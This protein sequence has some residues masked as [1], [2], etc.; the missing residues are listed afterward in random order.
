MNHV[1]NN[2]ECVKKYE[3]VFQTCQLPGI[4][5]VKIK[6]IQEMILVERPRNW[7]GEKPE[8]IIREIIKIE[9]Y[10]ATVTRTIVK[11]KIKWNSIEKI[12]S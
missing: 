4:C 3:V 11:F 7:N 10:N 5:T 9:K 6:I 8:M 2:R 12:L 1:V